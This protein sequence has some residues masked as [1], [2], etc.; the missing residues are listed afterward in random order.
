M[1]LLGGTL[2][3]QAITGPRGKKLTCFLEEMVMEL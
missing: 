2:R 3:S 1:C